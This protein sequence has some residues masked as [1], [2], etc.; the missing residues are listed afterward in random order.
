[1]HSTNGYCWPFTLPLVYT[2][3]AL[4]TLYQDLY[5]IWS[6]LY[7]SSARFCEILALNHALGAAAPGAWI[8]W[9]NILSQICSR[10]IFECKMLQ[11]HI[12]NMVQE[13]NQNEQCSRS[14]SKYAPGAVYIQIMLLEHLLLEHNF[15]PKS[16][17]SLQHSVLSLFP[18]TFQAYY[19]SHIYQISSTSQCR[20]ATFSLQ[21]WIA[22]KT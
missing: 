22:L 2:P 10:S 16:H 14:M 1:M 19:H 12:A 4:H 17:R 8:I 15:G 18:F 5:Q 13:H 9:S 3:H 20:Y 7:H 6:A 11:V 21:S